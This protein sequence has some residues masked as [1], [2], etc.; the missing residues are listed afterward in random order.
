[1]PNFTDYNL[2]DHLFLFS[3]KHSCMAVFCVAEGGA[4]VRHYAVGGVFI[5]RNTL[6]RCTSLNSVFC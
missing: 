2:K 6:R 3:L 4:S 1:M 5:F